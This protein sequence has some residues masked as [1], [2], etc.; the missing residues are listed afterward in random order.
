VQ[1]RRSFQIGPQIGTHERHVH[2]DARRP[3]ATS[4]SRDQFGAQPATARAYRDGTSRAWNEATEPPTRDIWN[5]HAAD[6]GTDHQTP[7]VCRTNYAY[8]RVK[9][10][11]TH[12]ANGHRVYA[13]HC[14]PSSGLVWPDDFEPMT[15]ASLGIA[16]ALAPGA[17]VVVGPFEWTPIHRGHEGMLMSVT[18]PADRAN[19]D[20][21]TA[22][23]AAVGPTP[24]WRLVPSDNNIG[25]RALIPLL[26]GGARYALEAAFCDRQ[27]WVQNPFDTTARMELRVV[28]DGFFTSRGW[29]ITFASPGGAT[30]SLGP[31]EAR[32]V[33]PVLVSGQDFAA[34]AV[35]DAGGASFTILTLADG[36]VVGG[37]TYVLDPTLSSPAE[38][39]LHREG[40]AERG[41]RARHC[42]DPCVDERCKPCP[43]LAEPE[44][45]EPCAEPP[46]CGH[47]DPHHCERPKRVRLEIALAS[48]HEGC[49][50]RR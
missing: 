43:C 44:P 26:G 12:P 35:S 1:S 49:D 40:C 30:F 23:P 17:E 31:R 46:A 14:R 9:N 2:S 4:P 29:A 22:T 38:E 20:T 45:K 37:F 16:G 41:E 7:V 27:L 47:D 18:T 48:A 19:N 3:R 15:T 24:A 25:F 21:P 33:R 8:V 6:D 10:R 5:R 32:L 36:I 28:S 50:C 34:S 11:G 39:T 13:H 42:C